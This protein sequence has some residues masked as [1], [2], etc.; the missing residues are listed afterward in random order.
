MSITAATYSLLCVRINQTSFGVERDRAFKGKREGKGCTLEC[1]RTEG[2][3]KQK[4]KGQQ[5]E[6]RSA[7]IQKQNLR[8]LNKR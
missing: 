3:V 8:A 7:H 5:A 4:E 2:L 6:R 1:L